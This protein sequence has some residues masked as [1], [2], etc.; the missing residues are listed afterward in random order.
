M[1]VATVEGV[2]HAAVFD[3]PELLRSVAFEEDLTALLLRYLGVE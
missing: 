3:S 2:I 1:L